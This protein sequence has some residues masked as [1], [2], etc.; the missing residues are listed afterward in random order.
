MRRGFLNSVRLVAATMGGA[1]CL[2]GPA[3]GGS[4]F[5]V[6]TGGMLPAE[7]FVQTAAIELGVRSSRGRV[8]PA[9]PDE[10]RF[11]LASAGRDDDSDDEDDDD[12]DSDDDDSDDDDSH[13]GDDDDS[14]DDDSGDDDDDHSDTTPDGGGGGEPNDGDQGS[15]GSGG[16][17]SDGPTPG[18]ST[19]PEPSVTSGSLPSPT[20]GSAPE[21]AV[22]PVE[23]TGALTPL[24][25]SG[26]TLLRR[27]LIND[28]KF[29]PYFENNVSSKSLKDILVYFG[30][31]DRFAALG[32]D[33]T[34]DIVWLKFERRPTLKGLNVYIDGTRRVPDLSAAVGPLVVLVFRDQ[35]TLRQ[36]STVVALFGDA[37]ADTSAKATRRPLR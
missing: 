24:L 23:R 2:V 15:G 1:A 31:A 29:E 10:L 20:G 25:S 32:D 13:D 22:P 12:S 8:G 3:W 26:G 17:S 11:I 6:G 33:G 21:T 16:G 35:A 34:A 14:D 36:R 4:G 37:D 30:L 19:G 9:Q 28:Q 7:S 18:P 5:W 27:T